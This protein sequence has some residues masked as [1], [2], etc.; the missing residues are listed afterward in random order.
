[1]NFKVNKVFEKT[2]PQSDFS[3]FFHDASAR[4][5]KQ[6]ISGAIRKANED[7]K[8]LVERYKNNKADLLAEAN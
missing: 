1:M 8:N 6:L 2:A 7:Q 4:D 3:T 5:K